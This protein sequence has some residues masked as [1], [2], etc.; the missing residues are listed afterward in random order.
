MRKHA[1]RRYIVYRVKA[2]EFLDFG[3]LRHGLESGDFCPR[4]PVNRISTDFVESLRTVQL[5]WFANFVDKSKDGV[6]VIEFWKELFPKHR[7]QI[8]E[9]WN[10]M[11]PAWD[12][13]R[14]FRDKAGF[15]ADKPLAFFKARREIPRKQQTIT[16]ALR[17][18]DQLSKLILKAETTELPDL[19]DA[20]DNLLDE[21]EAGHEYRYKR[22]QKVFDDFQYG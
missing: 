22:V 17:E 9:A 18:F 11:K 12:A 8:E 6:D 16:A 20:V 5:S 15:H 14:R 1:L 13:F 10:R 3:A 2:V 7:H 19:E 4:T 21:L